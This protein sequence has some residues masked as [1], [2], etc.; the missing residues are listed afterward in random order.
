MDT[1]ERT[2]LAQETLAGYAHGPNAPVEATERA[3]EKVELASAVILVE[4]V[5]DQIAIETL[6][7]RRGRNLDADQIVVVPV[8]GAQASFKFMRAF[9]PTGEGLALAGLCDADAAETFRR[10]LTKAK[11]GQPQSELDMVNLGF[12]VCHR[13]LEEELIRAAGPDRVLAVAESQGELGSFGT[14]QR[15]PEWR[16]APLAD[17]LHRFIQVKARRS[18]RYARLLVE[19]INSDSMPAPLVAVLD[20]AQL[21]TGS[22]S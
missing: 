9:G 1:Q 6:A 17:Q 13:D 2:R 18:L 20:A 21:S 15:Q 8:G 11:V 5:S 16:E 19:T 4:G 12:H 3:L 10:A 22:G 7:L 14:F